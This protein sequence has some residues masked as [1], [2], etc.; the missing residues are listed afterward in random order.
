M[1][2]DWCPAVTSVEMSWSPR[3]L[4]SYMRWEQ[5]PPKE[6][7]GLPLDRILWELN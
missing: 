5:R 7:F 6:Q 3:I 1:T 4:S 2:E